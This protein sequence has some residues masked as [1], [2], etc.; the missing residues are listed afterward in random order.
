MGANDTR[1][2]FSAVE[3]FRKKSFQT[4][5]G[6]V[7]WLSSEH[8]ISVTKSLAVRCVALVENRQDGETLSKLTDTCIR[9]LTQQMPNLS[10]QFTFYIRNSYIGTGVFSDGEIAQDIR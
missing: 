2:W 4:A 7:L 10:I 5:T 6:Y 9:M 3:A 8:F 1:A